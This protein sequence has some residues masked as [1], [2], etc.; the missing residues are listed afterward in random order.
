MRFICFG[1][2]VCLDEYKPVE[3]EIGGFAVGSLF[4]FFF[5]FGTFMCIVFWCGYS[6]LSVGWIIS[7]LALVV[8]F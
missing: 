6:F 8:L 4:F 2:H 7:R 3:A 1:S 5:H